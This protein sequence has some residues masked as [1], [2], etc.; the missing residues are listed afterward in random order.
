MGRALESV[1]S[2]CVPLPYSMLAH[3]LLSRRRDRLKRSRRSPTSIS[4][5][6]VTELEQKSGFT[7]EEWDQLIRDIRR[8][9]PEVFLCMD[10]LVR[11]DRLTT[12]WLQE[13]ILEATPIHAKGEQ[14]R[15]DQ[16]RGIPRTTLSEWE[17]RGFLS[18]TRHNRPNPHQSAALVIGRRLDTMRK[19]H[20]LPTEAI[21]EQTL[22]LLSPLGPERHAGKWV[23]VGWQQRPP[24]KLGAPPLEPLP[25]LLPP[26]QGV[27][28]TA[29]IASA[30]QGVAWDH[31]S[32]RLINTL[33]AVNWA[34]RIQSEEPWEMTI[35]DLT[36]W[37]SETNAF[38][39]PHMEERAR[40]VFR[41]LND[42]VL[43]RMGYD[44]LSRHS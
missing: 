11:T 16:R 39:T 8:I 32:W 1:L 30:W 41:E 14:E 40:D 33:G 36:R 5:P 25:V 10:P 23:M 22:R 12:R 37:V 20:W 24:N 15:S 26:S 35:A 34:G 27:E 28:K 3:A 42:I 6:L 13:T 31:Q 29:L 38:V 19:N 4:P 43:H 17:Q 7:E 21:D 2:M 44:L 9:R 18:Y